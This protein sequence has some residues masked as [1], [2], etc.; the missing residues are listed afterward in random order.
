MAKPLSERIELAATRLAQLQARQRLA[1]QA[2]RARIKEQERRGRAKEIASLLRSRDAHRK[3]ALGGVV[4]AA[5][6]DY[7]DPAELCGWL[8]SA[9][10]KRT[11]SPDLSGVMRERG[12]KRFA[13]RAAA[14]T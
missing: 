1:E 2:E 11:S 9:V 8:L 14:R 7:L 4:I 3:I 10:S 6:A 12:L 13:D 5:G